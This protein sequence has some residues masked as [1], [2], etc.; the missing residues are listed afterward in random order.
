MSFLI[1]YSI[2]DSSVFVLTTL[3]ERGLMAH[4]RL[5][6]DVRF[7]EQVAA[8]QYS[9]RSLLL[10]AKNTSGS[11]VQHGL[12]EPKDP[13]P[14]GQ[15]VRDPI[16]L[17]LLGLVLD[18]Q[19][20]SVRPHVSLQLANSMVKD[21]KAFI[22]TEISSF[23]RCAEFL[24]GMDGD[25]TDKKDSASTSVVADAEVRATLG[26]AMM[27]RGSY[28]K[29]YPMLTKSIDEFRRQRITNPDDEEPGFFY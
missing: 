25:T 3:F 5:H 20:R 22:G 9:C 2:C 10:N 13:E 18:S 16:T 27:S 19:L 11:E 14:S 6:H 7:F 12:L 23:E 26:H 28:L 21:W 1:H 4:L 17:G 24:L 29:A 8:Y 15:S